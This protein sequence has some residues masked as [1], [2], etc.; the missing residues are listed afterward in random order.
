[1]QYGS[2]GSISNDRNKFHGSENVGRRH[3]NHL[4]AGDGDNDDYT[5]KLAH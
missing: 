3:T 2:Q 1:M 4:E 5:H